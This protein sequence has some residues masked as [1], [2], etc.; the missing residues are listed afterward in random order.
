MQISLTNMLCSPGCGGD[1]YSRI[2]LC[3]GM[4]LGQRNQGLG[5]DVKA[6]PRVWDQCVGG[7]IPAWPLVKDPLE[8][9]LVRLA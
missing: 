1:V 3:Q 8:A 7:Y 6:S 2:F 9:S 4:G 5:F